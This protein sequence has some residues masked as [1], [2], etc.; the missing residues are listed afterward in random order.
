M[1]LPEQRTSRGRGIR[2]VVVPAIAFLYFFGTQALAQGGT[3]TFTGE[4]VQNRYHHQAILLKNGKV[5]VTQGETGYCFFPPDS[6]IG[7]AEIYDPSTGAFSLT[8]GSMV[9]YQE[10]STAT[11]L[12]DGK[13]LIAGG[14]SNACSGPTAATQ[15]FDPA[16]ETFTV[17]GPM[18]TARIDHTATLLPNGKVLIAGGDCY[19]GVGYATAEIFDPSSGTFAPTSPMNFGRRSHTAT[20]LNDGKVLIAG[21]SEIVDSF[22][23]YDPTTGHFAVGGTFYAPPLRHT[24]TLLADGRVLFYRGSSTRMYNPAIGAFGPPIASTRLF[25]GLYDNTATLLANGKVLV[26]GG[27]PETATTELF[28]PVTET[29]TQE[30][31]MTRQRMGHAAAPLPQ[32]MVLVTGG[33]PN[34]IG[35]EIYDP[36]LRISIDIKP[37]D[38]KTT[39]NMK[40][41]G[42]VIVA[43]LSAGA[44]AS[45]P[46]FDATTVDP[47]SVT[48]AGA[49]VVT[50]GR[51]GTPLTNIQDVNRD[52][53]V[54]LVLHF[55]VQD[56]Q[57]APEATEAVL[58]G[59]TFSGQSIRGADSV[60]LVP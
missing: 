24:A 2:I 28:D 56:L 19:N 50:Q 7:T 38:E 54:D 10:R 25:R 48:L 23:L 14:S 35:A 57:L 5:L 32:G 36:F 55:K 8:K 47:V 4:M 39:I 1:K 41:N 29:F 12:S 45:S 52:G 21:G 27:Y 59:E 51:A 53:R 44:S 9:S 30:V 3:F 31:S 46:A 33:I 49:H 37:G 43:I 22:E 34:M 15:L 16:T 6:A 17:V 58:L 11:L 13:V 60:R 18:G 26:A 40:S 20:L 42:T